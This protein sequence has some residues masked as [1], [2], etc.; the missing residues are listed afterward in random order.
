[1]LALDSRCGP[2]P[3]HPDRMSAQDRIAEL[4]AILAA[5]LVRLRARQ[6]S[7]LSAGT[8][9]VCVDFAGDQSGGA[10]ATQ[11]AEQQAR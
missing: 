3:L 4:A 7:G 6:S 9:N 5:G 10:S 2:S 8:E 11:T 1:M